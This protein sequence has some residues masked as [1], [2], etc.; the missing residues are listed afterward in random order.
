MLEHV[1]N[2][3]N[4]LPA[5]LETIGAHAFDYCRSLAVID[6]IKCTA[7]QTIDIHAF[8]HCLSLVSFYIPDSVT[9]IRDSVF[10]GCRSLT[11]VRLHSNIATI[12]SNA[13][14][15]TVLRTVLWNNLDGSAYTTDRTGY[16]N[17]V[18]ATVDSTSALAT[19]LKSDHMSVTVA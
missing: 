9:G 1:F 19:N 6:A 8:A 7:L 13:F 2:K 17:W 12:A 15:G 4:E 18:A 14:D 5:N 10:I 11:T 3:V 16:D